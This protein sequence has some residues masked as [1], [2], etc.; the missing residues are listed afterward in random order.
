MPKKITAIVLLLAL[1][2]SLTACAFPRKN[3]Q[4]ST[5]TTPAAQE[6]AV[7]AADT[8]NTAEP[9]AAT[10]TAED[11]LD[12]YTLEKVVI[13]SRHNMRAPTKTASEL[14]AQVSPY[15]WTDYTAPYGELTLLGGT[16]ET[17]M[18]QYFRK[19]LVSKGFMDEN[20]V[21]EDGEVRIY[22]NSFQRTIATAHY[23]STGMFPATNVEVE[24]HMD[25][26]SMDP[27]FSPSFSMM[28]DAYREQIQQEL[29]A[30]ADGTG[31]QGYMEQYRD[32][33]ALLEDVVGFKDSTYAKENNMTSFLDEE[34]S[35]E[36]ELDSEPK[37]TGGLKALNSA[38]DS[39]IMQ[40]Y[41]Q[42]DN[43]KASFG[44]DLTY[45]QWQAIGRV[46]SMYNDV[47]FALPSVAVNISNPQLKELRSE[48]TNDERKF[49]FLCGHDSNVAPML[50]A[51]GVGDYEVDGNITK[52]TPIGVKL[53][54]EKYV[55]QDGQA[56]CRFSMVYQQ[57]EKLRS[58][59]LITLDNP[60]VWIS[61]DLTGLEKNADGLYLWDD[62]VARFDEAIAA[63]DELPTGDAEVAA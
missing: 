51:L 34:S 37:A 36:Y 17:A 41:A 9:K 61:L 13:F 59:S 2:F 48:M 21:P 35:I 49:T 20:W 31:L 10:T 12:G 33:I 50:A 44:K 62:V 7:N 43:V 57:S 8:A 53:V 32:D 26:G 52:L 47:L 11:N 23:F 24:Y 39:L 56:Y 3:A 40:Y 42:P 1:C 27:V 25:V 16:Q 19:Y 18:G 5:E 22:A 58:N 6:Q 4:T 15:N 30:L 55:N 28:N 29:D 60:P 14:L 63:Y 45:E 46:G 54:W 38:C